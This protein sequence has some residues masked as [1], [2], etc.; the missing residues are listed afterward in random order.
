MT[1]IDSI[2]PGTL[3]KITAVIEIPKGSRIKYEIDKVHGL[4]RIDRVLS[5]PMHYPANYGFIPQTLCDD[6]DPLDILVLGQAEAIPLSLMDARPVGVLKMIDQGEMDDKIIA[7][8]SD[9]PQWKHI[10][11]LKEIVPQ[12]LHEIETFFADYKKLEKKAVVIN[13]ILDTAEA[14]AVITDALAL[15]LKSKT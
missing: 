14:Q 4:I 3:E 2:H 11:S 7:I 6:G 13:G 15:Y 5:S 12:I 10:T 8:H 9:D 1:L